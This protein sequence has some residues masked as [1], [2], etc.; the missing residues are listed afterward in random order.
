MDKRLLTFGIGPVCPAYFSAEETDSRILGVA[1]PGK[2]VG[3]TAD[4]R[5]ILHISERNTVLPEGNREGGQADPGN[6]ERQ[7]HIRLI[8]KVK[9]LLPNT[10]TDQVGD[11]LVHADRWMI[12]L[13][14]KGSLGGNDD[15]PVLNAAVEKRFNNAVALEISADDLLKCVTNNLRNYAGGYV[16]ESGKIALALKLNL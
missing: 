16:Q 15:V 10:G 6:R 5:V 1:A 11:Q 7:C 13:S 9:L 12:T 14:A 4:R 2:R 8:N 3:H